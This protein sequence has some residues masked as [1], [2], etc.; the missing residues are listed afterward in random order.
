[1]RWLAVNVLPGVY[2]TMWDD[3]ECEWPESSTQC[4]LYQAVEDFI[5]EKWL[6]FILQFNYSHLSLHYD[7]LRV[8]NDVFLSEWKSSLGGKPDIRLSSKICLLHSLASKNVVSQFSLKTCATSQLSIKKC[9]FHSSAPKKL[10]SLFRLKPL[11][12]YSLASNNL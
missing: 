8:D 3:E 11:L 7:G 2:E 1:M 9:V 10:I 5:L 6:D 4:F 12:S